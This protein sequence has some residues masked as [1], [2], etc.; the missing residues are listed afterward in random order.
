MSR[1]VRVVVDAIEIER[2]D[3]EKRRDDTDIAR[4]V[5]RVFDSGI[6]PPPSDLRA[7]IRAGVVTLRGTLERRS[8][9]L[10]VEAGVGEIAGVRMVSN[11]IGLVPAA[12]PAPGR[13]P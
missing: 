12:D 11:L 10:A 9:C 7:E 1:G 4:D 6:S 5:L 3:E 2:P 8:Q 13:S